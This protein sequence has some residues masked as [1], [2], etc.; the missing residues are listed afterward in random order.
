MNDIR[1][2]DYGTKFLT[3]IKDQDN[4]IYPITGDTLQYWF[5]KPDGS[6]LVKTP[7]IVE[8]G[9]YGQSYYVT[10]SGDI[11]ALGLWRLQVRVMNDEKDFLS[12]ITSFRVRKNIDAE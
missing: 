1:L 3:T 7:T 2:N 11:N 8:T 10:Q 5:C 4:E 6:V 12:D 9:V